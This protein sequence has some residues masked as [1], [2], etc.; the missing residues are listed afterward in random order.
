LL[1]LA[2]AT[3]SEEAG[4]VLVPAVEMSP[5]NPMALAAVNADVDHARVGTLV[6]AAGV[7]GENRRYHVI[8]HFCV[9]HQSNS[10]CHFGLNRLSSLHTRQ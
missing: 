10:Y 6:V 9:P 8:A 2:L 3:I 5:A 1:H 4:A 7:I